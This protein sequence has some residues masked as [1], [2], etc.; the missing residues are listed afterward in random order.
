MSD[1]HSFVQMDQPKDVMA[2]RYAL[3]KLEGKQQALL[4]D[5]DTALELLEEVQGYISTDCEK[6]TWKDTVCQAYDTCKAMELQT[7]IQVFLNKYKA[8]EEEK[9]KPDNDIE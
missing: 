8:P 7:K 3:F 1:T 2:A 6:C 5:I 9:G 4:K